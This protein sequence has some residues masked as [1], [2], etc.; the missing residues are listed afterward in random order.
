MA[1]DDTPNIEQVFNTP[2]GGAFGGQIVPP[3]TL[4]ANA[5]ALLMDWRWTTSFEGTVA[6]TSLKYAFPK[7]VTDYTKVTGYPDS[8]S[9]DPFLPATDF[10]AAAARVGFNLVSSYTKLKTSES[11]SGTAADATFRVASLPDGGTS[12][13]WFPP[14]NGTY[15]P[16]DSRAAGDI[17]LAANGKPK[18]FDFFGTDAF[19][20]IIHEMGH[21]L[22]LKHGHDSSF[23]GALSPSVNDNEFS[24]MT[25]A[26]YLGAN[27]S[28]VTEAIDGSAPQ[29]YM[30][31]D[32]AALQFLYGANFDKANTSSV[33]SWDSLGQEYI[34]GIKA[35]DT[36]V[37]STHKIFTTVWTQ[38]ATTTYDF[39]NFT[40]DGTYDLR[41]GQ[42]STF[43][44]SQLADLN[45]LVPAG[46]PQYLAHGNVYNAL[47]YNGDTRSAVGNVIA[48]SGN[49]SIFGNV[50]DNVI[51][52]GR[53][54]DKIDG[55][56]GVNTSVYSSAQ[57]GYEVTLFAGNTTYQIRDKF[58]SDGVDALTRIDRLAFTD[59]TYDTTSLLKVAFSNSDSF[60]PLEALY[61]SYL[62]RAPD[63]NGMYYWTAQL[64]DN[65]VTPLQVS[66]IFFAA[67]ETK[68]LFPTTGTNPEIVTAVYQSALG[69]AADQKGF[70]YWL[71]Q[72]QT[73]AVTK[74]GLMYTF[75]NSVFGAGPGRDFDYVTNRASVGGNFSLS[76]GLE[77]TTWA[78]TVMTGVSETDASRDAA[79]TKVTDYAR[80]VAAEPTTEFVVK[81]VGVAVS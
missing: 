41:P 22:G 70:D 3:G 57:K 15:N 2:K 4:D 1:T 35:P 80:I 30:M 8:T 40:E 52:G 69:R 46:T 39:R 48:G 6:A 61:A 67:P 79:L 60:K 34:N 43:S 75:I 74:G 25:Y 26:S 64:Y 21:A 59:S 7:V 5:R 72:L 19:N 10:Q 27:T 66:E 81:L 20:T 14:N 68:A 63:A 24:V 31:Y 62:L 56:E 73:G 33:Y 50:L 49:D 71:G 78:K 13:A 32:I 38:G 29:S 47:L 28:Q 9:I 77:N 18:S 42:W 17:F 44:K 55:L 36:G 11:A 65:A 37:S 23:N 12:H 58:G 76:Q 54:N 51:T 45:S 16:S 53:G